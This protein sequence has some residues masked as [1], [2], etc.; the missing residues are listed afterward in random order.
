MILLNIVDIMIN[1][2]YG[3]ILVTIFI[4]YCVEQKNNEDDEEEEYYESHV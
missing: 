2:D 3:V 4:Y 1:M